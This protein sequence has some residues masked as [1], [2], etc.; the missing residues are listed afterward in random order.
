[1]VRIDATSPLSGM[2]H[3]ARDKPPHS[4]LQLFQQAFDS[5][6]N[7]PKLSVSNAVSKPTIPVFSELS[8]HFSKRRA[9]FGQKID[10]A[11]ASKNPNEMVQVVAAMGNQSAESE[12]VAKLVGKSVSAIEQ[13]TK[14]G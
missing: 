1:M 6:E 2:Q 8:E 9:N 4:D 7:P 12:L 10:S 11:L 13:L 14:L 5:F 3:T